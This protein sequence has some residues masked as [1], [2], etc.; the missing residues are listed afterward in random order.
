M[1]KLSKIVMSVLLV[2]TLA[3][4]SS[5]QSEVKATVIN[6]S[7]NSENMTSTEIIK[8]YSKKKYEGAKVTVTGT[9]QELGTSEVVLEEG[10]VIDATGKENSIST[11]KE[12]VSVK[13][14]G[15]ITKVDSKEKQVYLGST[16]EHSVII[17][18]LS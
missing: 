9:I 11:F 13:V 1:K 12:G 2:C 4:C 3:A 14:Q 16:E 6:N 10:F 15:Y 8:S 7:G 17:T 5:K 18:R